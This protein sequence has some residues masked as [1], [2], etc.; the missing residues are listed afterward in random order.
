MH[1]DTVSVIHVPNCA[2]PNLQHAC[3]ETSSQIRTL[4]HYHGQLEVLSWQ[5]LELFG[6]N[7]GRNVR[8]RYNVRKRTQIIAALR[9]EGTAIPK[10][11]IRS[12]IGSIRHRCTAC[13]HAS[14]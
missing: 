14:N 10:N 6:E 4:L 13:M 1:L 8:N 3:K 5:Q 12:V 2:M 9:R 11:D 7:L